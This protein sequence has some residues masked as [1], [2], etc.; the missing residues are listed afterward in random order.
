MRY[1]CYEKCSELID[2]HFAGAKAA[3][4]NPF[5]RTAEAVLFYGDFHTLFRNAAPF[6][7]DLSALAFARDH[8]K[9]SP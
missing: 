6:F 4:F 9:F 2:D 3:Y 8:D 7:P 1:R 5:E